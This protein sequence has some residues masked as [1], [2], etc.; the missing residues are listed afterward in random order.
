MLEIGK[1]NNLVVGRFTQH[2]AYLRD[3]EDNEVL[4]PNRYLKQDTKEG[5]SFDVFLYHDSEDRIV[6][7]TDLPYA[8]AGEVA[9][10]E[11]VDRNSIGAFLD[12]GL[13]K[14][15]F[16]PLSNQGF[17]VEVGGWYMVGVYVDEMSGRVTATTKLNKLISNE[18]ITVGVGDEVEIV[19]AQHHDL[20][21]RVVINN[22]NWGMIYENQIFQRVEIGDI[23]KGFV[24]KISEDYRID[25]SLQPIGVKQI[26]NASDTILDI[27]TE[28]GGE[29]S[30]GDKST[31]E[32][33]YE[34]T[35]LSKKMFKRGVGGLLKAG[36]IKIEPTKIRLI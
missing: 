6:A 29:L 9:C 32:E 20:G 21:Y 36:K 19:I 1:I 18:T 11:V 27:L 12:W 17:R 5:D 25:I 15:L 8:M 2:G 30:L 13:P 3:D 16:L 35:G 22:K 33:I 14:D 34:L 28:N 31:P 23:L 24:T 10:M 7:S 4:L 26:K